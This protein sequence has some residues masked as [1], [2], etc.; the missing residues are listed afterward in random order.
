MKKII[1]LV[2]CAVMI[3]SLV[4]A[5]VLN[6]SAAGEGEW[7][8][9][10]APGQ[11]DEE[12]AEKG[13]DKYQPAPGYHYDKEGFH[14]DSPNYKDITPHFYVRSREAVNLQDGVHLEVRIDEFSYKGVDPDTGASLGKDEWICLSLWGGPQMVPGNPEYG[15]GWLILIRGEGNGKA[16]VEPHWTTGRNED[17]SGGGFGA[18]GAFVPVDVPM[19]DGK[20]IYTFDISW[21][22]STYDITVN[23]VA[24][25]GGGDKLPAALPNGS[26]AYITIT[27]QTSLLDND[28]QAAITILDFN[29]SVPSGT[30]SALPDE[31]VNSF[32]DFTPS[33]DIAAG[34]PCFL[35]DANCTCMRKLPDTG[36]NCNINAKGDGTVHITA[37]A[38]LVYF[39]AGPSSSYSYH[40]EDFPVL[41]MMLRNYNGNDGQFWYAA[42]QITGAQNDAVASWSL[43]DED[44]ADEY[45]VNGDLY[46]L[47]C[48]DMSE[49]D[50]DR[51]TGRIHGGNR[52]V[53][54]D[55]LPEDEEFGEFDLCWFAA[56]RTVEEAKAYGAKYVN[57]FGTPETDAPTEAPTEKPTEAPTEAPV[58]T[59]DETGAADTSEGTGAETGTGDEGCKS[60]IGGCAA[61]VLTAAAAAVALKRKH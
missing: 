35:W 23:G 36:S 39:T 45:E 28:Q 18:C 17:G 38:N 50:P 15:S 11:S 46:N 1:A 60:V 44:Y 26:D 8:T 16:Q 32:A 34:D 2:I 33:E 43:W 30:D 47:V 9:K 49:I 56:F 40:A 5:V 3:L 53:F 12:L 21:N 24:C 22:G 31:N 37:T 48:V 61:L 13:E 55:L 58:T 7:I 54:G 42:G 59:A 41:T 57:Q 25:D 20:E 19:E 29:G 6:A 4:P 14:T 52:L 27:A 51:W 10:R